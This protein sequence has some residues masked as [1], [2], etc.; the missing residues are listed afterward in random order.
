M[1]VMSMEQVIMNLSNAETVIKIYRDNQFVTQGHRFSNQ[2][3]E[4]AF[5]T[6]VEADMDI[7]S[8]ICKVNIGR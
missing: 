3:I 1:A 2:I 6:S 7:A 5:R 4:Y 8:N